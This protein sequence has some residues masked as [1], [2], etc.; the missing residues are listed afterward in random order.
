MRGDIVECFLHNMAV[1]KWSKD[2]SYV[3][4]DLILARLKTCHWVTAEVCPARHG[5]LKPV[6]QIRHP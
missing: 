3:I 5:R 2:I 1:G 4:L 6:I